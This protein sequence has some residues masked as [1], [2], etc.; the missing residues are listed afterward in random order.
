MMWFVELKS[1]NATLFYFGILCIV[2]AAVFA[3]LAAT[4]STKVFG[5]SAWLKP[6]KFALSTWVYAWAMAWYIAYLPDFNASRFNGA[7]V[8]LLGFEVLYIAIQAGRGELSHYNVSS[9]FYSAMFSLMAFAATAVTVYTA[10]VGWL[11][12]VTPLPELPA[13]Y[14]WGIR[15]GIL[16]FTVFALQ[17]FVMGSHLSHTVGAVNDN[18]NWFVVGWSRTVGDLRVAHFVGMHALQVLPWLS[19]YVLKSSRWTAVAAM[20]YLALAGF[21]LVQALQGVPIWAAN[22]TKSGYTLIGFEDEK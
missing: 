20:V 16:I 22:K 8:L 12:V 1:R 3:I 11:F 15:F 18:S 17:G 10:Y 6:L 4:T 5:V 19:F 14:V 9:A 13:Y 7:V 2:A 21:T